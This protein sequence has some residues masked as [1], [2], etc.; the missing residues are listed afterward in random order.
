LFRI[1]NAGGYWSLGSVSGDKDEVLVPRTINPQAALGRRG[2][3]IAR[4][5]GSDLRSRPGP[6]TPLIELDILAAGARPK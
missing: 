2:I 1:V 4:S 3:V 5:W 6:C